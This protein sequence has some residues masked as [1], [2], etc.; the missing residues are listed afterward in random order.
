M[1]NGSLCEFADTLNRTSFHRAH[2]W[3]IRLMLGP[4]FITVAMSGPVLAQ[5]AGA[6]VITAKAAVLLNAKTGE[7]LYA[8]NPNLRLP[9]AS[10]TKVLT[11]LI[12][13]ETLDLNTPVPVSWNAAA[14]PPS[15][16]GLKA[17]EVVS[18]SDLLYGIMLK[19]G[20]DAATA[21]A[22]KIG[23][24][25]ENF[26]A[27]MN[28]RARQLGAIN[29]HFDNPHGLPDDNHYSTA[30]DLAV[31]FRQAMKNPLF[32]EITGTKTSSVEIKSRG[33]LRAKMVTVQNHNRLL[34]TYEG[35]RGGKTGYTR[36][37][38]RCFVGEAVR[39]NASII[40]AVLGSR[41]LWGDAQKLLEYGFEHPGQAVTA[42]DYVIEDESDDEG[43]QK[44]VLTRVRHHH[45]HARHHVK[46][47]AGKVTKISRTDNYAAHFK[48]AHF[49]KTGHVITQGRQE[50]LQKA[51]L[52][53]VKAKQGVK[54]AASAGKRA[55]SQ[56]A[57]RRLKGQ[58]SV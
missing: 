39:D 53:Q 55:V 4:A 3:C 12:A 30:Y 1:A 16:L 18:A 57:A 37:A 45:H 7:L 27:L 26:A 10:T 17:G 36:A 22:E 15:R 9:P 46:G 35:M 48:K 33:V 25:V 40:V 52:K 6:P 49:E 20:N 14:A 34:G 5:P 8:K 31:I 38:R 43:L 2:F 23:G 50:G 13:L 11:T 54:T 32:A 42:D 41:N 56:K 29:S 24:S 47:Q 19:S 21:I 51:A 44:T 28:A 58:H